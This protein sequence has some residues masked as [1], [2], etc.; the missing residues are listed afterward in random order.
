MHSSNISN[1]H[2]R[3]QGYFSVK[4]G[5]KFVV[6][7]CVQSEW[8]QIGSFLEEA[9]CRSASSPLAGRKY[10]IALK[11]NNKPHTLLHHKEC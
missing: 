10:I 2:H 1:Y 7:G 11:Q 9:K 5:G 3:S 8:R 4:D 6:S